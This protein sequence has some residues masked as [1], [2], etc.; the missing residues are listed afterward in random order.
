[1][2][3]F[4]SVFHP[5]LFSG[6]RLGEEGNYYMWGERG[7]G[8]PTASP[9]QPVGEEVNLDLKLDGEK[10]KISGNGWE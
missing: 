9:A 3:I 5:T 6:E 1:M 8:D 4:L 10:P 2:T 7:P